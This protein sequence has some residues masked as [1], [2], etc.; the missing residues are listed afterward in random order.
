MKRFYSILS[1][2]LLIVVVSLVMF[3]CRSKE[4]ESAL[5]Y[6]NQ[7]N[8]W[9]KAMEQLK[10]AVQVN[11]ADVEAHVLLA[12][13]FGQKGDYANMVREISTAESLMEGAPNPKFQ[14]RL[15]YLRD[16]YWRISFNKGVGNVKKDSLEAAKKDFE[17][18]ILIDEN[19][20]ESYQ[21]LGYVNVQLKN[22]DAAI[23]NYKKAVK[24]N[25]KDTDALVSLTNLYINAKRYEDAINACDQI[26]AV[27]PENT[28]AIAQKAMAYD[29]LGNSEEA[30]KAYDQAL[31]KDP[32]NKDLL[33]NM[34]RLY[35]KKEQYEKAIEKFK[36]VIE[37]NPDDFEANVNIG[38]AYLLIAENY[39]KKY[40]D[41]DEK[42]LNKH[43]KEFKADNAKAKEFYK[44]AI[45][46]L[47]KAVV[48][49]PDNPTGW[50]NL[51]VAYVQAG[52]EKK[53]ADC[54][55]ISD[56]VKEN[57]LLKASDFIDANLSHLK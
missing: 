32:N 2:A 45:P 19:R 13:G 6:I 54:F 7:Q 4:V 8:D 42:Q 56:Q 46:Y 48:L 14:N 28:Q 1:I 55:T 20:P 5:I 57:N 9:D 34:G 39:L 33:F 52:E 3:G 10:I 36:S 18:C 17:N 31:A 40:R 23:E 37:S 53:G 22:L 26:L 43:A 30:F 21:N 51:G 16:K 35:F 47:E 25:P 49:S 29:L 44:H 50:Y 11:P 38:N 12:E 15:N 24:I 27:D 41:M